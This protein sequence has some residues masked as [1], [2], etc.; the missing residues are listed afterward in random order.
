[1]LRLP[2]FQLPPPF[3][4]VLGTAAPTAARVEVPLSD[5]RLGFNETHLNTLQL[6]REVPAL[7]T[8]SNILAAQIGRGPQYRSAILL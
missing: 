7:L 3:A 4:A 6:E 5:F 2:R 8:A 1:V